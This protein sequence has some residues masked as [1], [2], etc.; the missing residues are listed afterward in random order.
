ME[1]TTVTKNELQGLRSTIL[2]VQY[3]GTICYLG[4]RFLL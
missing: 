2:S 4:K 3:Q 1:V